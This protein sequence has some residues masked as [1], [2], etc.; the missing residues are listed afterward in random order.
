L[1]IVADV[2][3]LLV[4]YKPCCLFGLLFI[5]RFI[6]NAGFEQQAVRV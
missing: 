2:L 3:Y 4:W 1:A 5:M 6:V